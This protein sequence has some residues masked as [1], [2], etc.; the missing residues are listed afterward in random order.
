VPVPPEAPGAGVSEV[1]DPL[2]PVAP[3]VGVGVGL[4][5]DGVPLSVAVPP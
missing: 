4:A 2:S 5:P 3:G 1:S